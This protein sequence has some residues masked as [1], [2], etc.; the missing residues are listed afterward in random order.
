MYSSY[1][2]WK[3]QIDNAS[4]FGF[5][6]NNS[7]LAQILPLKQ[8]FAFYFLLIFN[9][10]LVDPTNNKNLCCNPAVLKKIVKPQKL[11]LF[12]PTGTKKCQ[13]GPHPKWK[14]NFFGRNNK[15]SWSAFR[16]F[17]FYQNILTEFQIF[18]VFFFNKRVISS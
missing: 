9:K 4:F 14:T 10:M 17:L 5:F 13:Y 1:T 3:I 15:S 18:G 2:T 16:N 8:H 7:P 11:L 12:G 6:Y